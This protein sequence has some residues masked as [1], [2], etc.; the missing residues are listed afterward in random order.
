MLAPLIEL[1]VAHGVGYPAVSQALK[2]L[3]MQA[4][5]RELAA[6]GAP[7]TDAAVSVRSGVHRKDVRSAHAAAPRVGAETPAE[8]RSL[9]LAEQVF[10]RWTTD[11]A[12][13]TADG[14]PAALPLTGPAPSFDALVRSITR[15]LSRRTVLDELTRLGL[16]RIDAQTVV[17]LAEAMVPQQGFA[18]VVRYLAEHLHDHLAAG[19]ANVQAVARGAAPPFLE[20]SLYANGLS[21]ESIRQLTTLARTLWRPAFNQLA[22]AARQ[23]FDV[24]RAGALP[25]RVRIGIYV[26][27]DTPGAAPAPVPA[28]ARKRGGGRSRDAGRRGGHRETDT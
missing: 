28:G 26:Y 7:I 18:D 13:R 12:Y 20:H 19:A 5:R 25:G 17:P 2:P 14:R 11:A 3:F 15:D 21:D 1:L 27:A 9:S 16:V 4:A 8:R 22:D 23:R 6:E 24:D 10:T